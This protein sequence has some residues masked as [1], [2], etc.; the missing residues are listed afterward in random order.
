MGTTLLYFPQSTPLLLL[1]L[2]SQI[3]RGGRH[4]N[5]GGGR[6]CEWWGEVE[7]SLIIPCNVEGKKVEMKM[8][9]RTGG[10]KETKENQGEE[11]SETRC[12]KSNHLWL[13]G[14]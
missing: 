13:S 11:A 10:G 4:S 1:H 2:P 14:E 9:K 5:G 6:N 12:E 3:L 7:K 8:V